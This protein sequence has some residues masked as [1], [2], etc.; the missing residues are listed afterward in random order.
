[1]ISLA[2]S[3]NSDAVPLVLLVPGGVFRAR[4]HKTQKQTNAVQ[5]LAGVA[6]FRKHRPDKKT[7]GSKG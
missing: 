3:Q 6:K 1:M 4:P 2:S 7:A 5:V